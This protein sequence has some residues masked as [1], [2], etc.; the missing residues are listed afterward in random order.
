[1]SWK[2]AADSSADLPQDFKPAKD[3]TI[4]R[5]PLTI[6]VD[7]EDF[8][9]NDDLDVNDMMKKMKNYK[10]ASSTACPSP[11][12]WAR[13]F[14]E[15]DNTIAI[16]MTG[17]LS[18]TYNAAV[19]GKDMVLEETPDKKIHIIDTRSTAG[20][21]T[22][23][24]EYVN[25]LIEEGKS[26]EEIVPLADQYNEE[27][28]TVFTLSHYDNLIKNGRMS[29]LMGTVA[30]TLNIRIVGRADD[31]KLGLLY[32]VRG[33]ANAYAKLVEEMAKRKDLTGAHVII[34]ETNNMAGATAIKHLIEK[35]YPQIEKITIRKNGGL[36]SYYSEEGGI[37][38]GF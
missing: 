36:N 38:L 32:K 27:I 5:V 20:A 11:E 2:I 3:T 1:M 6:R 14:R 25:K 30:R 21:E 16:T 22:L 13:A 9:D 19:I 7:D 26:F 4:S 18:G 34:S 10:G 33:E 24:A 23:V 35:K 15:A 29:K 17:K 31:G 28:E 8:V 37:I 12:M